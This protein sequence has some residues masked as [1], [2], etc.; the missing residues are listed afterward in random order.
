MFVAI[1][2]C[3]RSTSYVK[4]CLVALHAHTKNQKNK[5]EKAEESQLLSKEPRPKMN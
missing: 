4:G 2:L 5:V 1:D 3:K